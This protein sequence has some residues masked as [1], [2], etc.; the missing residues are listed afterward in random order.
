MV[1]LSY[2]VACEP[3]HW[4]LM[5]LSQLISREKNLELRDALEDLDEFI[6]GY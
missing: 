1:H 5:H 2:E 3:E 6:N 4:Q